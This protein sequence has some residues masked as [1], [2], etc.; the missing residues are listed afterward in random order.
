M[1]SNMREIKFR[2]WFEPVGKMIYMDDEMHISTFL[3]KYVSTNSELMQYI[4]LHDKNEKEIYHHDILKIIDKDTRK[5]RQVIVMVEMNN[6]CT[7]NFIDIQTSVLAG[8]IVEVIGNIYENPEF[9]T[10][11]DTLNRNWNDDVEDMV[12]VLADNQEVL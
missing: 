2:A 10:I 4:G 9:D 8:D 3:S 5:E 6:Y 1:G 12:E 7:N 11:D